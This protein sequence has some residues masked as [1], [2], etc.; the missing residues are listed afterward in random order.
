MSAYD[1]FLFAISLLGAFNAILLALLWFASDKRHS[2]LNFWPYPALLTVVGLVVIL[3]GGE[4]S[5]ALVPMPRWE[6]FLSAAAGPL[7][8]NAVKKSLRQKLPPWIY[9]TIPITLLFAATL[10][11]SLAIEPVHTIFV[12]QSSFTIWAWF[13]LKFDHSRVRSK[14]AAQAL[15]AAFSVLIV[16]QT[17][18][19]FFPEMFRDFVP[20]IL[21]LLLS[22]ATTYLLFRSNTL[23]FWFRNVDSH[24]DAMETVTRT[25]DWLTESR[26]FLSPDLRIADAAH[27]MGIPDDLLSRR[28][29]DQGL[30][31]G[32]LVT[33]LRLNSAAARLR[34]R[35]EAR[36]SI[37]AIGLLSGYSSRSGFYK[38]FSSKFGMTPAAYRKQHIN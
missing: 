2:L 37:E 17:L 24:I 13:E 34:L 22:G 15:V 32:D 3:I 36:T 12:V 33:E 20:I 11:S 9:L 4:H 16:A 23:H 10:H 29:N 26:A 14:Q 30:P 38:A 1:T 27:A 35:E 8:V 18:R 31:F 28:L 7:L 5:G 25:K 21:A 6:L 19:I